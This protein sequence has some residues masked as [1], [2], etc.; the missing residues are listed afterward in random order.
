MYLLSVDVDA[1]IKISKR[2]TKKQQKKSKNRKLV[3]VQLFYMLK[4]KF[5]CSPLL[6]GRGQAQ[7]LLS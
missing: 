6:F 7:V 4:R 5:V 3:W 1:D 2:F